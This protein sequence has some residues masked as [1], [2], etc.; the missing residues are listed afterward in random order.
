MSKRSVVGF[1]GAI[2]VGAFFILFQHSVRG[3]TIWN[4][5]LEHPSFGKIAVVV[6]LLL[7]WVAI[8]ALRSKEDAVLK[9]KQAAS[10][11]QGE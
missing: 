7:V 5:L 2:A 9:K 3:L 6:V 4:E 10:P 8:L 1:V 11:A